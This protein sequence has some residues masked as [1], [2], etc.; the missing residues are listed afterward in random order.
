MTLISATSVDAA[1]FDISFEFHGIHLLICVNNNVFF[2]LQASSEAARLN[3]R[4]DFHGI[5]LLVW[6]DDELIRG[7]K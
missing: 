6:I 5:H 7:S 2:N 1:R 3:I 4:L